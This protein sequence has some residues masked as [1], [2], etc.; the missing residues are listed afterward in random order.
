MTPNERRRILVVCDS[1]LIR[2]GLTGLLAAAGY[3]VIG[4]PDPWRARKAVDDRVF[5]LVIVDLP[6]DDSA[7]VDFLRY[8][9][10]LTPRV[11]VLAM[12]DDARGRRQRADAPQ[13]QY[14]TLMPQ[15]NGSLLRAVS[16]LIGPPAGPL[17][18]PTGPQA[19]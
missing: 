16:R 6:F 18:G 8:L 13:I 11:L 3:E 7:T 1:E 19:A 5:D 9:E 12:Y 15:G 17:G 10:R 2:C 14:V 4:F